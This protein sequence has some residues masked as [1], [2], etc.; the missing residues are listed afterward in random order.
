LVRASAPFIAALA[1]QLCSVL[2]SLAAAVFCHA[3]VADLARLRFPFRICSWICRPDAGG[4][5]DRARARGRGRRLPASAA[6]V[7]RC[8][9]GRELLFELVIAGEDAPSSATLAWLAQADNSDQI[10]AVV[11]RIFRHLSNADVLKAVAKAL[12]RAS[13]EMHAWVRHEMRK[14]AFPRDVYVALARAVFEWVDGKSNADAFIGDCWSRPSECP[15]RI[16][17]GRV[18]RTARCASIMVAS[19]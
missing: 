13:P 8:A 12:G 3:V 2:R 16:D 10:D 14:F 15:M 11:P 17:N 1:P 18:L 4:I 9:A 5:V 7:S 19:F 6:G